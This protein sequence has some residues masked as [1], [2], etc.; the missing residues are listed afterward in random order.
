MPSRRAVRPWSRLRLRV[1]EAAAEALGVLC[2][3]L[4]APGVITSQRD[5]R[6]A[7]TRSPASTTTRFE[8]YFPPRRAT[9]SLETALRA[10]VRTLRAEFPRLDPAAVR[11]ERFPLPDYGPALRGHFPPLR[12]G[13]R[14]FVC[15]PWSDAAEVARARAAGRI[16]IEVEPGQAFGTGHHATT[17]GCLVAIERACR[18]APPARALD[19]GCGSGILAVALCRLG[20]AQVVGVDVDPLAREATRAAARANGVGEIRVER[21]LTAV[22][23]R[24]DLVVANLF[25]DLLIELAPALAKRLRPGGRLVVS[26]LLA[27]QERA[28]RDALARAG[29]RAAGRQAR[30]T[31]VVLESVAAAGSRQGAARARRGR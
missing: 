23:G 9:R 4:G 21:S 17:R 16:T 11:L 28:V 15:T 29:L 2:I 8:A 26:G 13:R 19:V 5:L 20:A 7:P 6:R 14:L 3:E 12:V 10:G 30:S 31:W 22:R 24:F 1:P 18:T 27:R 25:A